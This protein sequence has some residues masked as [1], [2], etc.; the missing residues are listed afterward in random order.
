MMFSTDNHSIRL[1]WDA[2]GERFDVPPTAE[3]WLVKRAGRRG[4]GEVV[5]DGRSGVPLRVPLDATID[6]LATAIVA[7]RATDPRGRYRLEALDRTGKSI[8]GVPGAVVFIGDRFA[9]AQAH[10]TLASELE[11]IVRAA[12]EAVGRHPESIGR[13]GELICEIDRVLPVVTKEGPLVGAVLRLVVQATGMP[14]VIHDEAAKR[15]LLPAR[16][17]SGEIG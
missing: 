8:R 4:P 17:A 16:T 5:L 11:G 2:N 13:V 1:A 6:D 14:V 10:P 3:C 9:P 15:H 7:G 12:G